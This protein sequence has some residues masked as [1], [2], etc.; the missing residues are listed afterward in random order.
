MA[1]L[2]RKLWRMSI[3]DHFNLVD[4]AALAVLG[5]GAL[6]IGIRIET[7]RTGLKP[8]V[9]V[10]MAAY[11]RRWM[12]EMVTRQPRIFDAAILSS[13]RQSTSFFASTCVIAI[14]GVLA[15]V[16]NADRLT[17]LVI[18][19]PVD[20]LDAAPAVL[21]AKLLLPV[22]FLTNAFLRFVWSNRL[23]GYCAV[24][25]ASVPNDTGAPEAYPMAAQAAEL[26]VRA[27][28]N[29]NRGLRSMYFA[30]AALAWLIGAPALAGA[31]CVTLWVLWSREF[32]SHSRRVLTEAP[33]TTS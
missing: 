4:L 23:F 5:L 24:M 30:L 27:A 26:N 1:G 15:L 31:A 11:R 6:A 14:G 10:L 13:L 33:H 7:V 32:A 29:F 16:G 12:R 9:T 17:G 8:S 3:A 19:L 2:V 25:M 21:Q 28:W 22:L 18:N 20:R